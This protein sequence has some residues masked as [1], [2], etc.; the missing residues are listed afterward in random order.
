MIQRDAPPEPGP[1]RPY[2][3]P[4]VAGAR[5]GNAMEVR[6]AHML[7]FKLVTAMIVL[8]AGE[9]TV[10][11][12]LDGLAVL[13]GDALEGGTTQRSST[14]LARRLEDIGASFGAMTGWDST[15]VAVSCLAEHLGDAMP[16]LAEMVRSPSFEAAE[17]DRYRSQRTATAVHRSMDPASLATDSHARFV[18]RTGDAYARPVAGTEATLGT[19]T[20]D[21]AHEF[22]ANRYGPP[23]AGVVI[24][25]DVETAEAIELV[26]REFADWGGAVGASPAPAIQDE[27][28]GRR[29]HVV[30]R[31]GS[32]QSEIRVGHVGVSRC[33]E[34]YLALNVVN[35]VLGGSFSSRLNLNLRERHGFTYGV[36]SS[37]AARRG[38]GPFV[39][40][41]AVDNAATAAAVREIVQEIEA[42]A[43]S[44]PTGEEVQA[45]TSYLA[46]VFPLRMA[47]TGQLAS[48]IAGLMVFDL[49]D[50]YYQSYQ[51][52]V[53]EVTRDQAATAAAT[54]VR[55]GELCTVVV[56]DADAVAPGLEDLKIGPVTVH[57]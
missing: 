10:P 31:P 57:R 45:A 25:G 17:F 2:R 54:Y 43:E 20:P 7:P 52:R 21:D 53:R 26:E 13:T 41:T 50:D 34:D 9:T 51:H 11:D 39:V 8:R 29:V 15:T 24:V 19:V 32:V 55:P 56:G 27:G 18:Y 5:L 44:G 37:F 3:F 28:R 36:R 1:V 6:V 16:L 35:L 14:D 42:I 38:R 30:H 40:S 47:T 4:P 46:G 33:I 23:Q 22:V 48:R 49:P 12:G